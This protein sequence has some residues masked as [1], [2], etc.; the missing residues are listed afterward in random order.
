MFF[1]E[2]TVELPVPAAQVVEALAKNNI[3]AGIPVSR[4]LPNA[5]MDNQLLIAATE[6][7]TDRDIDTLISA[8]KE[9]TA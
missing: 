4:L 3:I 9:V 1:N 5:K 2:I 6:T 8:L 7:V